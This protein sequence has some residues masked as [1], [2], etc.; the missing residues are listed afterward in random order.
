MTGD[1]DLNTPLIGDQYRENKKPRCDATLDE[2]KESGHE[3]QYHGM[4]YVQT[5]HRVNFKDQAT[6]IKSMCQCHNETV[7]LWTH[8]TG[9]VIYASIAIIMFMSYN[10]SGN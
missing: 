10:Y 7:N 1:E 2:L 9:A 4:Q 8:L 5:G 3:W 6:A